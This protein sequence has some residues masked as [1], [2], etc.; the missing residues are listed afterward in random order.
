MEDAF[1]KSAFSHV[2]VIELLLRSQIPEWADKVDYSS[3]QRLSGEFVDDELRHRYADRVWRGRSFDAGTEYIL[4]LEFQGRPERQMALRTTVYCGLAVQELFR[5]DKELASGDRDLAVASLVLHHGDR[6]WNAPTCLRDLFHDSAPDTYQVVSRRPPDA[7]P[8]TPLDLPQML[9]GLAALSRAQD[10]RTELRVLLRV[11]RDV[12]DED[13]DRRLTGT[14]Q[15]L[16]RSKGMSSEELEEATTMQTVV[17][18][19]E[20]SLDEIRQEGRKQGIRQG[21][22]QGIELGR[23]RVLRELAARKFGPAVAENLAELLGRTPDPERVA[24]A[25]EALLDCSG[26][27]EFLTRVQEG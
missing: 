8:P 15:A 1:F 16:L 19:F 5:H 26:A 22:K 7:P 17:T 13:L 3:L 24:K 14:V 11:V 21:R 25:T 12:E 23:V 4:V 20:R 18:A 27:E 10:M 9:L 6:Q 2:R